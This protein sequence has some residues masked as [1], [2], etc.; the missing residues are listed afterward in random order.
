MA[1][2]LAEQRNLRRRKQPANSLNLDTEPAEWRQ[3]LN[4]LFKPP[5]LWYLVMAALAN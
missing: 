2:E 1:I 5:S 3:H 4:G